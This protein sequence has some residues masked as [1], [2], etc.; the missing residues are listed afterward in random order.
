MSEGELILRA[1]Q[2][3]GGAIRELYQRYAARVVAIT[4]RLAGEDA[5]AE[6]WAQEAW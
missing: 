6:D 2:G 1:Q 5:L 3:D 4:R